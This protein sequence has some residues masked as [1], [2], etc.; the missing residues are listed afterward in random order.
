[1][2]ESVIAFSAPFAPLSP[3]FLGKT[4]TTVTQASSKPRDV[5]EF[6]VLAAQAYADAYGLGLDTTEVLPAFPDALPCALQ[7]PWDAEVPEAI[8]AIGASCAGGRLALGGALMGSADAVRELEGR[9]NALPFGASSDDIGADVNAVFTAPGVA[10]FGVRSLQ[11][12]R[13]VAFA[14]LSKG[15]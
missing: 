5:S 2:I 11:S 14:A 8:G 6:C 10:L 13:D 9:V 12:I 4:P 7:A 1:M 3:T 15:R